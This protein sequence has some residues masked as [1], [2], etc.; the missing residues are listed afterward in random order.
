[1]KDCSKA[2]CV[3]ASPDNQNYLVGFKDGTIKVLDHSLHVKQV[4]KDAHEWISAIKFSPKGNTVAA[5]S[6]DNIVYV[7]SYPEMKLLHK[8]NKHA[9][10]IT[11]IDFSE[12]GEHLRSVCG[13]YELLFWDLN[14]GE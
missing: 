12:N 6:H 13:A 7:Y 8:L 3:A 9:S 5:G 10:F 1:L 2:R 11:H 14:K 4:L